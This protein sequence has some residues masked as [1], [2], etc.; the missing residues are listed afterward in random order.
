MKNKGGVLGITLVNIFL[1]DKQEEQT[2]NKMAEHIDYAVKL[3][4]I[5]HVGLGLDICYYLYEG[6]TNTHVLNFEDIDRID[7]LYSCLKD[8]GYT[9]DEIDK[10]SYK[11]FMRI[12]KEIL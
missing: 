8:L 12:V 7:N 4:G 5:Y 9:Q 3:I 6:K 1:S 10:I 2:V 11:N